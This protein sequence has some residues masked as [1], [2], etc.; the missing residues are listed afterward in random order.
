MSKTVLLQIIQFSV[1][2][3]F[4][5]FWS[6]DITL[7][8]STIPGQSRPES[9]GYEGVFRISQSC[10]ITEAS[11]SD[12]L[13]SYLG[14][15]LVG[16]SYPAVEKQSVYSTARFFFLV[17]W[18]VNLH[19]LFNS[20]ANMV[21]ELQGYYLTHSLEY[22]VSYLFQSES[23]RNSAIYLLRGSSPAH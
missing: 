20:K 12:C 13:V 3:Q 14:H 5:Y 6:I 4:S 16:R 22:L 8:V 18:H 21:E 23:E 10:S 11:P 17:W 7:S 15:S 1:I 2:T 19:G 9:D